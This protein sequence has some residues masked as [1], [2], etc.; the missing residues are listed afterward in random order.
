TL[1][2]GVMV[3]PA[4]VF[5]GTWVKLSLVAS[6]APAVAVKGTEGTPEKTALRR[7]EPAPGP[8]VH[9]VLA[10]PFGL[11]LT[12]AGLTEPPPVAT[13]Q[14]IGF[15]PTPLPL[16]SCSRTTSESASG[17]PAEPVWASPETRTSVVGFAASAVCVKLT[18]LRP[19]EEASA[20]CTPATF[21]STRSAPA[22]PSAS[23]R[24][25]P[26]LIEPPPPTVHWTVAPATGLPNPS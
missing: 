17:A 21:P 18:A 6:P 7:F 9:C 14:V 3:A 10:R 2:A 5:T 11:V 24:T 19:T 1:T 12:V 16:A 26:G 20:V 13:I 22:L 25:A 4:L 23:V 15:P 8:S